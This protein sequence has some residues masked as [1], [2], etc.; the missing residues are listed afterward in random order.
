MGGLLGRGSSSVWHRGG[1]EHRRTLR[2][3]AL[4]IAPYE[5]RLLQVYGRVGEVNKKGVRKPAEEERGGQG[6]MTILR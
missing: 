1:L 5:K 6:Y 2:P 3:W 4:G